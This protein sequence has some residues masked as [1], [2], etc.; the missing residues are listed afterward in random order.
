MASQVPRVFPAPKVLAVVAPLR[1][2]GALPSF[3]FGTDEK[4][5]DVGQCQIYAVKFPNGET[6][7]IRIPVHAGSTLTPNGL[8]SIVED[9][10]VT[11]TRMS[12]SGIRWSPRLI[13]GDHGIDNGLGHPYLALS[14]IPGT[15]LEWS[16]TQ[17]AKP[18]QRQKVLHQLV[19]IQL[20]LAQC[21]KE[22]RPGTSATRYLTDIVDGKIERFKRGDLPELDLQSCLLHRE[23]II[24]DHEYNITGIIGWVFAR[25]C[26]LQLA[27]RLPRFLAIDPDV[28]D[29]A[30]LPPGFSTSATGSIQ[31]SAELLA[32]R[33]Y[34]IS[35]LSDIDSQPDSLASLMKTVVSAPNVDW[36]DLVYNSCFSKGL[37]RWMSER[38][39]LLDASSKE[40]TIT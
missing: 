14:W 27:L 36:Q 10:I 3:C 13:G 20:E 30:P 11:L 19:D 38:S 16:S 29:P 37:H 24:V 32:D 25:F 18:E 23:L 33:Q 34:T 6:W 26:P 31:P 21:T 17:P 12:D 4:P 40:I 15:V 1:K 22:S 7:A 39:W 9:E 35:H 2:D 8:S 5:I 28:N